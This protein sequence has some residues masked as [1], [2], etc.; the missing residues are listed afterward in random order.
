MEFAGKR[1]HVGQKKNPTPLI[2][3]FSGL[4]QTYLLKFAFFYNSHPI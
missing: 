2:N 4:F 1:F 3:F